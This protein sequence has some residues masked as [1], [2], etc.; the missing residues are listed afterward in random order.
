MATFISYSHTDRDLAVRV[1]RTLSRFGIEHWWMI[2]SSC[3]QYGIMYF[4][5]N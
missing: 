4:K 1:S 3:P 2:A 5:T